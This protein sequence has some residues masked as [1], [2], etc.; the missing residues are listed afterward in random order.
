MKSINFDKISAQ[1]VRK[2]NRR[3]LWSL[4][5]FEWVLL[6]IYLATV[7]LWGDSPPLWDF[8]GFQNI[9]SL[10][11]AIQLFAVACSFL[12]LAFYR[13]YPGQKPSR[14]LLV[15]VGVIFFYISLI[16]ETFK[17][18][19]HFY[20]P[21]CWMPGIENCR[22]WFNIYIY[23]YIGIA[24]ATF[25]LLFKD[26]K[27]S[28]RFYPRASFFVGFGIFMFLFGALGLELF[29]FQLFDTGYGMMEELRIAVEEYLEMLG[30]TL[31]LY[32]NGLFFVRRI[33]QSQLKCTDDFDFS[34]F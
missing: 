14:R 5:I 2:L 24:I 7:L 31:T 4:L 19:Q 29:K 30:A 1:R 27:A 6:A 10:F 21:L 15:T 9:P 25:I 18:H 20:K 17:L 23:I 12:G 3:L 26:L 34:E 32:G 8:N 22:G 11:S 13:G 16:D 28:W 33:E